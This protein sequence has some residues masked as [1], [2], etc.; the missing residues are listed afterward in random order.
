VTKQVAGERSFANGMSTDNGGSGTGD[1]AQTPKSDTSSGGVSVA[2]AVAINLATTISLAT[3]GPV[4]VIANG[5]FTLAT[6]ADTDAFALAD[7]SAVR[8]SDTSAPTDST[9]GGS[10][11]SPSD[12]SSGGV[13]VGVA[14]AINYVRITNEARAPPDSTV[15]ATGASVTALMHSQHA[16]GASATSGAGGGAVGIAGS[17]AIE[18]EQ[19]HTT[20]ALQGWLDARTGDV[21]IA[22]AS[23]ATTGTSALPE[24]STGGVSGAG[25]VGIGASVP[26]AVVD[27]TTNAELTGTLIGGRNVTV[28]AS[29]FH[30]MTTR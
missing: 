14:V 15:S 17:V 27:D 19:I 16:L 4:R 21:S 1:A 5:R 7:G 11:G 20:A 10:S 22:A 30:A 24:E 2:A 28:S 26:V 25:A 8:P 23:D 13:S 12:S 6:T 9:S 18:I 29:T 3:I